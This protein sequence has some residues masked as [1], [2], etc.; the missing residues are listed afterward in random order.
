MSART[1]R[2]E[3]V[4]PA[5]PERTGI[6]PFTNAPQTFRGKPALTTRCELE[7]DGSRVTR[8][9]TRFEGSTPAGQQQRE[10][11]SFSDARKAEAFA[12]G[13]IEDLICSG[14]TEPGREA[15]AQQIREHALRP[16]APSDQQR[17][18]ARDIVNHCGKQRWF[19]V[20]MRQRRQ[21]PPEDDPERRAFRWPRAT[22]A[23]LVETERGLGFALPPMLR[24][25]YAEVANGGFGP[26]YGFVGALGGA[27]DDMDMNLSHIYRA[28]RDGPPLF[29]ESGVAPGQ[30]GWFE[31]FYDEWPL[32]V[33]RMVHWGCDIWSCL[34][35][36]TGRVH[37]HESLHGKRARDA[38]VVEA[39]S[40]EQWL[41]RWLAGDSL[42]E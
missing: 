16:R 7:I 24:T 10:V 9:W 20:D 36:R 27:P 38:M 39:D 13:C 34:D 31:P 35:T 33:L 37:R 11:E 5:T 40:L 14:F 2:L 25:L 3:H 29:E 21:K 1:R 18:I 42:W 41:T 28:Q 17:L 4:Q 22:E 32:R 23:Q 30:P 26:G 8:R 12:D 19:G 15:D 6:N